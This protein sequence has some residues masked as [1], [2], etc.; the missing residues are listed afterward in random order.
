MLRRVLLAA[1][2]GLLAMPSLV[3][4]ETW[5]ERP[6]RIIVPWPPGGSTDTIARI[7]QGRL[8]ELLSR[9]VVIDNR[10][11]AS[12]SIGAIEAARSTPDGYTWMLA[13]DNEATNQTLM[14]LPYRTLEAFAPISLVATGPLALVAH[15]SAPYQ[16]FADL[17][18]AAKLAPETI[19]FATSG[20]GGLAHVATTLLQQQG[21]FRLL[22]VPYRGG[23][24]ALQDAVAGQV[25]LFMSNVVII[26]QHIRAGTLRPLG[27]TT[28]GETRHV[29]GT[30]SFAGLGY[31]GFAAPTWWA[32]LGR[33]GTPEPILRR[34]SEALGQ[35]LAD[36]LV[37][38]RIEEQGADVVASDPAACGRFIAAEIARWG[39]VIMRNRISVDS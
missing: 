34:I 24:P 10:G 3:R 2:P 33:A 8:Q 16:T 36:P 25:P 29:P 21:E 17:V 31:P 4:A 18:A 1:T 13:Y 28:P 11:G 14:R 5:P 20:V 37:R 35:A 23:G 30:P 38:G 39:E 32:F 27:V 19:A 7:F 22:H 12:G 26:S 9:P 15:H 6:V